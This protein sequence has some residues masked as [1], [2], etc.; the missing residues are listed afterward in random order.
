MSGSDFN[1]LSDDKTES[2]T[3]FAGDIL[4]LQRNRLA[5]QDEQARQEWGNV[6]ARNTDASGVPNYA[7]ARAEA[8]RNPVAARGMMSGL[9]GSGG[10]I[11]QQQ[12]QAGTHLDLIARGSADLMMDPSDANVAAVRQR[13][14]AAGLPQAE[15]DKEISYISS[16]DPKGRQAYAYQHQ[17]GAIDAQHR[18]EQRYGT[19][20]QLQT[21]GAIQGAAVNPRGGAITP[22]GAAVPMTTSPETGARLEE[23][24]VPGQ[25]GAPGQVV[26]APRDSLPGANA[27]P[28]RGVAP[29]APAP[30]T[31][32][33][34]PVPGA[35]SVFP[36]GYTGRFRPAATTP[37]P[38]ATPPPAPGGDGSSVP[39]RESFVVGADGQPKKVLV[40]VTPQPSGGATPTPAQPTATQPPPA[41]TPPAAIP[42]A[43]AGAILAKPPQ[44]Q[45]EQLETDI[46]ARDAAALGMS[47]QQKR[48][49]AGQSAL[50][51]L[52]LANTGPSTGFFA[53]AYA[54]LQAQAPNT[55]PPQGNLSSTEYRQLLVKNLLRFAQSGAKVSGTD[56]GL[57][58]QLHS[59]ANADEMLAGANRHVLLQ[60]LGILK[61]DIA[62]T[63]EMPA[64]S[65]NADVIKHLRDFSSNTAPEAFMWDTYSPAERDAIEARYAKEGHTDKLHHS[66]EI[67]VRHGLIPDPRKAAQTPPQPAPPPVPDGRPHAAIMPQNMLAMGAASQG[68]P[69]AA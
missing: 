67:A 35:P 42:G 68:N 12:Q 48:L 27:P 50:E 55:T 57:E 29:P 15:I 39:M 13:L 32:P 69:L 18:L 5:L 23:V 3:K 60:D 21:G 4:Q 66:L 33:P 10:L 54:F 64:P 59:N 9:Q 58:A 62:Q 22:A 47:D 36:P 6:L 11:T 63:K 7:A 20:T 52:N 46:K 14:V 2:P 26:K 53:R 37:P 1:F 45:P 44:G 19:P 31:P 28:G 43:P 61:R 25:N 30:G 51:A 16:L 17:L 65:G 56:L 41:A 8:A 34:A 24:W 40:P 38:P 49:I